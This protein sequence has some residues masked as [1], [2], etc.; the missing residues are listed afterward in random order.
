MYHV[1]QKNNFTTSILDQPWL[2][3]RIWVRCC[4]ERNPSRFLLCE[5]Y[6]VFLS[7][8]DFLSFQSSNQPAHINGWPDQALPWDCRIAIPLFGLPESKDLPGHCSRQ[9]TYGSNGRLYVPAG[10]YFSDMCANHKIKKSMIHR[11]KKWFMI[12]YP[13]PG[14]LIYKTRS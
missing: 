3:S 9:G 6:I 10:S 11:A 12:L 5:K 1:T 4:A 13:P 2:H 14:E 8:P 7:L